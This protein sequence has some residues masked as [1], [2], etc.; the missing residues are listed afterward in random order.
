MIFHLALN[1]TS[2]IE[3]VFA[4]I[5]Q[6]PQGIKLLV[7]RDL[8][9]NL[10]GPKGNNRDERIA[11]PLSV[12]GLEDMT[13]HFLPR[14]KKWARGGKMWRMTHQGQDVWSWTD[15][16]LFRKVSNQDLRHNSDHYII[17]VCL[18]STNLSEH[19]QY[20]GRCTWLP[21]L[22]PGTLTREEKIFMKFLQVV[23]KPPEP[24]AI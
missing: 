2:T 19:T 9:K 17:L 6:L 23:L 3:S 24:T 1:N 13:A 21:L 10:D 11:V 5:C 20:L 8:N 14:H 4:A 18:R 12:A 16:Q 7:D 15:Q 22:P